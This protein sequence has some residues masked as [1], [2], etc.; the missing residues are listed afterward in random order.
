MIDE[1]L[2]KKDILEEDTSNQELQ[3]EKIEMKQ[4]HLVE[5]LKSFENQFEGRLCKNINGSNQNTEVNNLEFDQDNLHKKTTM[6]KSGIKRILLTQNC[7]KDM[8]SGIK[9]QNLLCD[10]F[11]DTAIK[12]MELF[13]I[14]IKEID[15]NMAI[16]SD[17]SVKINKQRELQAIYLDHMQLKFEK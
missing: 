1:I 9:D 4:A 10:D 8:M 11:L 15:E 16:L 17:N 5:K 12:L 13:E 7:V 2:L 3:I 6:L 14:E